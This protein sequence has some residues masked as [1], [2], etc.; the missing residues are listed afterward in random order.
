[1]M[2]RCSRISLQHRFHGPTDGTSFTADQLERN[3]GISALAW[4]GPW[5]VGMG[6]LAPD[7]RGAFH[8]G[9]LVQDDRQ[10]RGIGK[11]IV[12][13]LIERALQSGGQRLH[14]DVL[15]DNHGLLGALR[16]LGKTR[17]VL[18]QG[19]FSVDI[20][21]MQGEPNQLLASEPVEL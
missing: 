14:A 21:L 15:S 18:E 12:R 7:S 2:R 10:R 16:R 1:M 9:V 3:V 13:S 20:D 5:C 19:S 8:L 4:E 11:Q 6:A 17:V